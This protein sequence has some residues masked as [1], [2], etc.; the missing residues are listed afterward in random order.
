ME[1]MG[2]NKKSEKE[3]E[4]NINCN[5]EV[6]T[7]QSWISPSAQQHAEIP[8]QEHQRTT[9]TTRDEPTRPA[10]QHH[11]SPETKVPAETATKLTRRNTAFRPG[12][13]DESA[14]RGKRKDGTLT[15]PR[16]TASPSAALGPASRRIRGFPLGSSEGRGASGTS[17]AR[18]GRNAEE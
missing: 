11:R 12:E 9:G 17:Q 7:R 4:G 15:P 3:K 1:E 14:A 6:G 2:L 18:G 13:T 16:S 5:S 8:P 10:P